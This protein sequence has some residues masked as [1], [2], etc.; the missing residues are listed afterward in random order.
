SSSD[1]EGGTT[2]GEGGC[3][4]AECQN[5]PRRLPSLLPAA[6]LSEDPPA[7]RTASAWDPGNAFRVVVVGQLLS[8][9]NGARR[10]DPDLSA[11]DVDVAVGSACVVDVAGDIAANRRVARPALVDVEQ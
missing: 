8:L 9:A 7:S 5:L 11:D 6:C 3:V 10:A 1:R 2:F 4:N